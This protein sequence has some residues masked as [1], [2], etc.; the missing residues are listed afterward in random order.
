MSEAVNAYIEQL[1]ERDRQQQFSE[2]VFS[3]ASRRSDEAN[4]ASTVA[5]GAFR[6][7]TGLFEPFQMP[8]DALFAVVSGAIN[9]EKSIKDYWN[10][11][12]WANYIPYGE[13]PKRVSSGEEILE[14][15]G[16]QDNTF[17]R[18]MG[19]G[20]DLV[21][22]PLLLGA[23]LGVLGR[24]A[25]IAGLVEDGD[26]LIKF[27]RAFDDWTGFIPT[28][29]GGVRRGVPVAAGRLYNSVTPAPM[30]EMVE[31]RTQ[32]M[33][34]GLAGASIPGMRG[35]QTVGTVAEAAATLF[36]T[37]SRTL[38]RRFG[39]ATL[40]GGSGDAE[41]AGSIGADL[42]RAEQR[43]EATARQVQ[44]VNLTAT[45]RIFDALG[46]DERGYARNFFTAIR[47]MVKG[48][49]QKAGRFT[50]STQDVMMA[51]VKETADRHGAL[52]VGFNPSEAP[53]LKNVAVAEEAEVGLR[54]ITDLVE[55]SGGRQT[56]YL[57][58]VKRARQQVREVA[59][60]N[61]DDVEAAERAFDD[62]LNIVSE[63]DAI[64]GYH[65]SM[66]EPVKKKIMSMFAEAGYD[67]E[68]IF[69]SIIGQIF[70]GKTASN[71]TEFTV[72]ALEEAAGIGEKRVIKLSE[73]FDGKY[74]TVQQML[75]AEGFA[76]L[77]LDTYVRGLQDGHLRRS[78]AVF[79]D[80][81]SMNHYYTALKNGKLLPSSLLDESK[82]LENLRASGQ[83][84]RLVDAVETYIEG[85][86]NRNN[87]FES[88]GT[89]IRAD[90]LMGALQDQGF[91]RQ[92]VQGVIDEMISNVSSEKYN[93]FFSKVRNQLRRYR[94]LPTTA[95]RTGEGVGE[96]LASRKE[97]PEETLELLGELADPIISLSET[98]QFAGRVLPRQ[99]YI[100]QFYDLAKRAGLVSDKPI[101]GFE[102]IAYRETQRL[103]GFGNK[104]V[105]PYVDKELRHI[106][107][108]DVR[109]VPMII[110]RMNNWVR[111]AFLS[112]PNIVAQ[113]ITGGLMTSSFLGLNAGTMIREMVEIA[114]DL[115]KRENDPTFEIPGLRE[116]NAYFDIDL[117]RLSDASNLQD[118]VTQMRDRAAVIDSTTTPGMVNQLAK[119]FRRTLDNPVEA[120][121]GT[122]Q[123]GR[124]TRAGIAARGAGATLGLQGFRTSE[125]AMKLA[126]FRAAKR[127]GFNASEA[128]E[129]ARLSTFDYSDL[130]GSLRA[131]RERGLLLFPGFSYFIM[132]RT[133]SGAL[134]RPGVFAATDRLDEAAFNLQ[135]EEDEQYALLS[136]MPQWLREEGGIPLGTRVNEDGSRVTR[137]IPGAQLLPMSF[138]NGGLTGPFRPFGESAANLG[139]Y[140]AWVEIFYANMFNQPEALFG[141]QYGK[142][143]FSPDS[144][145]GRRMLESLA[146]TY[147]SMA[148]N[149]LK[150]V[151]T[152]TPQDNFEGLV[153]SA[154]ESAVEIPD[155]MFALKYSSDEILS[156]RIERNFT[157]TVVSSFLRSAR[158]IA[159]T[160][161]AANITR[162]YEGALAA[163]NR[164]RSRRRD[165]MLRARLDGKFD[166]VQKLIEE[167]QQAQ[168]DFI[169]NWQPLLYR[170]RQFASRQ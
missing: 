167:D 44:D 36:T 22:D 133:L 108:K 132:G 84:A 7:V 169:A 168:Q 122:P 106:M 121:I 19:V 67:A 26:R 16:V 73:L 109:E 155:D 69:R 61:G 98:A 156:G 112:G 136:S 150:K 100:R 87:E 140:N 64:I 99:E 115:A 97:L 104:Y 111:S 117:S 158:P 162:N 138:R 10:E 55:D 5:R 110:D 76:A 101:P 119:F 114:G 95:G 65:L 50:R 35:E 94:E 118:I 30:R 103:G 51:R 29:R 92:Q 149:F 77:D 83:D 32:Q 82:Y 134:R 89:L 21:A 71:I 12:E 141:Q 60:R 93:Q 105:H 170:Q 146:Y 70:G 23:G 33:L 72:D 79:Q 137:V 91:T 39:R 1:R 139:L 63:T 17:R 147:N 45:R 160:G 24:T 86:K 131:L 31:S 47:N 163:F 125:S 135:L 15:A 42:R 62:I 52:V 152:Y 130:P 144:G 38:Q 142:E 151:V 154:F 126:A 20:L 85:V 59:A 6:G 53:R 18:V 80:D 58:D 116:L 4:F 54:Q 40:E 14:L 166:L 37:R 57:Q 46:L 159:T 25:K 113:N 3:T 123:A 66:F 124:A 157:D 165:R 74:K 102:Q 49:Q 78:F 127:Q 48:T 88:Y 148:P 2:P 75:D 28:T 129:M 96:F 120:I 11:I 81:V 164:A 27:G 90:R 143:V 9:E 13:V 8:Q 41:L 68:P 128:A 153:V 34:Q 145:V 161:P 43:A 56:R 107:R